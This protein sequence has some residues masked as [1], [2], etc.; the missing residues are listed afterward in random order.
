MSKKPATNEK[1]KKVLTAADQ[2]VPEA[3][4]DLSQQDVFGLQ[5][6][7][8]ALICTNLDSETFLKYMD[9]QEAVDKNSA[10]RTK[11]LKKIFVDNN[12]QKPYE[13]NWRSHANAPKMDIA[14]T[15]IEEKLVT[16]KP[17]NFIP[18]ESFQAFVTNIRE[19]AKPLT[20]LQ[21]SLL[22]RVLKKK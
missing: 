3:S 9:F 18:A 14:I 10:D 8:S 2:V 19:G 7:A 22:S 5:F 12:V 17:V 15:A 21:V 16:I 4:M 20:T 1:R 11:A 6:A 13:P